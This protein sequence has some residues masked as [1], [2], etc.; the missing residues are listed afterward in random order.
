MGLQFSENQTMIERQM[1][2]KHWPK[3]RRSSN[4]TVSINSVI[5]L[6]KCRHYV[7]VDDVGCPPTCELSLRKPS[8][9]NALEGMTFV[10]FLSN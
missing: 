4:C 9:V 3:C 5:A 7:S 10:W 8:C 6:P 1:A 2:E